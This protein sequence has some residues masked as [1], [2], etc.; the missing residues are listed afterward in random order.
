M[1]QKKRL[2][3]NIELEEIR[4]KDVKKRKTKMNQHK[5]KKIQ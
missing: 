3:D 5:L 4:L 2:H 1:F